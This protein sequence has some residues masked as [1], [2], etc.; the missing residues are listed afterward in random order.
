MN[1]WTFLILIC[2]VDILLTIL[3]LAQFSRLVQ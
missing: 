2:V 1:A 3:A